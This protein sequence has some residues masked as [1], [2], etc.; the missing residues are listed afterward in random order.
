MIDVTLIGTGGMIP[1]PNRFLSSCLIEYN[2]KSILIDCGEGTQVSLSKGKFSIKK[3]EAILIT[4]CHADH[5][6]GLPG[7]L[8]SIGNNGRIEPLYIIVPRGG[9]KIINTLLVVCGFLPYEVII[10]ELH[11]TKPQIFE[12]IGLK[13]TSIPLKH[14]INCLGYSLELQLKPRFQPEKAKKLNI[15]VKL[16]SILH[17]GNSVQVN[18]N[19]ITPEM[20]LGIPR[21]SIKIS[22]VTDTRP[23][24]HIKEI[25]KDSDLFICEGMYGDDE[26]YDNAVEKKHMLFSEAA[27]IALDANVTELWLT[28]YSPSLKNPEEFIN[29]AKNI[30]SNTVAGYDLMTTNLNSND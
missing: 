18:N 4:H 9:Y 27:K 19:K 23:T 5:I 17:N 6:T 3:I 8:L 26:Q 29:V 22:Y 20:V 12:Q 7:L 24:K 25:V 10:T 1:L 28:H 15:P 13:I 16:W 2:G 30:F 14:H 11:E 21:K